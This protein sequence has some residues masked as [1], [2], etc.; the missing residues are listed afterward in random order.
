MWQLQPAFTDAPYQNQAWKST[1][2][3]KTDEEHGRAWSGYG[4]G[5]DRVVLN[6]DDFLYFFWSFYFV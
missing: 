3:T 6:T 2:V 4:L 1:G 5:C